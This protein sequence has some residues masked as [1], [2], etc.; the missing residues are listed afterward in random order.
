M[1]EMILLASLD[2]TICCTL[3]RIGFNANCLASIAMA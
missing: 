1:G 2:V 3:Y